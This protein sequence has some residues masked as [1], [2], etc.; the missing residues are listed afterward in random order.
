MINKDKY[1]N[2][3]VISVP[4]L[5]I[6]GFIA[7][8]LAKP[9]PGETVTSQ[10]NDHLQSISEE[11][12]AY[13]TKPPTSGPHLG[14]KASWGVHDEQ[15]SDELQL[16]NLED[17]GVIIHYDPVT[18]SD[19]EVSQITSIVAGDLDRVIVAPYADMETAITLTA[20]GKIM[21]LENVNSEEIVRFVNAYKGIDHH[22]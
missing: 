3:A 9:L 8:S 21:R 14:S 10:G 11:H 19:D 6:V 5:F 12:I 13:S 18:V 2:I 20:W 15:I 7:W 22:R 16:H 4:L 1:I 17:G